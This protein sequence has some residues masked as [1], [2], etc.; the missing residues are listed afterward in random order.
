VSASQLVRVRLGGKLA[1]AG[2][3]AAGFVQTRRRLRARPPRLA[4]GLGGYASGAVPLA[5]RTLGAR[6]VIHEANALPGLANRLRAPWA[7]RIY[8]GG[9]AGVTAFGRRDVLVTGHPLRGDIA[10]LAGEAHAA[11]TRDRPAR[12][13]VLSSTRGERF[14]AS[15]LPELLAALEGQGIVVEVVHQSGQLD[16]ADVTEAYRRTGVKATVA[17]YVDAMARVYRWPTS[18]WPGRV[19]ARL[20]RSPRPACRRCWSRC[21]TLPETI[22]PPTPP[23]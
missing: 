7:H 17:P 4:I 20:P 16:P 12:V 10:A 5:A 15:R 3:V 11:P 6:V 18:S 9:L 14:F 1:A 19:R 21:R 8:L 22:R 23:S 13:L 2:S